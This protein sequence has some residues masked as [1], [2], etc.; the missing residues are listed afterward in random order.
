[1]TETPVRNSPGQTKTETVVVRTDKAKANAPVT[2]GEVFDLPKEGK[3]DSQPDRWRVV[4]ERVKK[5]VKDVKFPAALHDLG[6]KI[7]ELFNVPLPDVMVTSWK[8]VG[9]LQELLEKSRKAPDEVMYLELAQHS[10][11][12][13]HKPHIEMRI[14]DLPVK[15]IEFLVKLVFNLKGFVLKIKAGA[16]QEIQTGACE[17][18]GTISYAG[19][20]I[21]EKKLTPIKLPGTVRVPAA[22]GLFQPPAPKQV[23]AATAT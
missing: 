11:N 5:E 19:N 3:V 8:K 14:K 9:G 21:V 18:K 17:V 4:E 15:K 13:E 23:K 6:P 7:C 10:I 1:M 16:I 2:I 20:V 12:S 22:L